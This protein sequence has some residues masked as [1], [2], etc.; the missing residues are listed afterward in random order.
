MVFGARVWKTGIA[1]AL[2]L[3]I[4]AWLNFSPPVIAA[5]AAIFAMQPSIYRSWRYFLDQLQTNILGAALA[6]LAGMFFSNNVIAIG[7]VCIIVI[8]LS[9]RMGMEETI[10]LTLV[11]VVAVME[12]SGEWQF[13]LNRL[14]LSLIGIGCAFIVNILFFPPKPKEQFAVQIQSIFSKMSLLL[15]TVISNEMKESVFRDEKEALRSGLKSLSDKYR[16]MEEEIKKLKGKGNGFSR[17]RELVVYKQKLLVMYKGLEV[18]DAVDEHYFQAARTEAIDEYFDQHIERLIKFH[19]H[20]LLKFD[21]KLKD[22]SSE[23]MEME[24]ENERF[25][26]VLIERYT[27]QPEGLLRL[28]IVA[29]A[30]Y[31]YGHQVARLDKLVEHDNRGEVEE[32]EPLELLLKGIRLK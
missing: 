13:A 15:R 25:M 7:L 24:A 23:G 1:V 5:V 4:S 26:T 2:S 30:I 8:I 9:L 3:Y 6:L 14:L 17:I 32:R 27:K 31:D 11:T 28:S 22:D 20:V 12:A 16:L 21:D 10:G 19:E 18:L 29:A